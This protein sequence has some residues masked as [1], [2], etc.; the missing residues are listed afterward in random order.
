MGT[1]SVSGMIIAGQ[2]KG[3]QLIVRG[4]FKTQIMLMKPVTGLKSLFS[5]SIDITDQIQSCE[6]YDSS[7]ETKKGG[8]G[9]TM[10][11]GYLFGVAGAL[12]AS[13]GKTKNEWI[14]KVVLKD[15]HKMLVKCTDSNVKDKLLGVGFSE[16]EDF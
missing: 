1:E 2:N 7:S 4:M 14:I 6:I 9:K 10:A 12:V 5:K 16:S 13:K 11:S 8:L 15:G 3:G